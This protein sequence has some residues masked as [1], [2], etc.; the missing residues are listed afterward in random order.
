MRAKTIFTVEKDYYA[1]VFRASWLLPDDTEPQWFHARS[2]LGPLSIEAAKQD[3]L[4]VKPDA[5]YVSP[6]VFATGCELVIAM[7]RDGSESL[8][9]HPRCDNE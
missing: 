7:H 6:L 9:K 4:A 8:M 1:P 2:P 5:V 3:V